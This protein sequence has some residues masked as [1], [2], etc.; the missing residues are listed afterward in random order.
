MYN[1]PIYKPAAIRALVEERG[2]K[3]PF[4]NQIEELWSKVKSGIKRNP[5]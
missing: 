4:L 1:A 5:T 2:Y 3:C